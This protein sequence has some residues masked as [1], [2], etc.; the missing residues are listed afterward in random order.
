M[1]VVEAND[2]GEGRLKWTG[3]GQ[4]G[5]GNDKQVE[6]EAKC[7]ETDEDASNNFLDEEEIVGERREILFRAEELS[8][9]RWGPR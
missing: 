4:G 9:S 8:Q 2:E 3:V 7:C 5:S 6:E 1:F